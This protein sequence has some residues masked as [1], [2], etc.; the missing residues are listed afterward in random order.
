MH[1]VHPN[2]LTAY[3]VI[4]LLTVLRQAKA[5]IKAAAAEPARVLTMV[6]G[7]KRRNRLA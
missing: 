5:R 7:E 3:E 2:E 4:A 6:R 1:D